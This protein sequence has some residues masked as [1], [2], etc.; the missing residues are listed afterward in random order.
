MAKKQSQ[1][2]KRKAAVKKQ[3]QKK[4]QRNRLIGIIALLAI[5]AVAVFSFVSNK[6]VPTNV[7]GRKIA[8]EV[9]AEAPDFQ[10]AG[11]NGETV[12]L[13]DLRGQPVAVT[14]MHTW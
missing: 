12:Q 14:F 9:G 3:N 6:N 10:L 2:Q 13:S 8:P 11:I 5:V 4:Q 7:E 1:T